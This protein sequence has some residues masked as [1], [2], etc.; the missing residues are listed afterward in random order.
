MSTPNGIESRRR[1]RSA[2]LTLVAL[3]VIAVLIG[4]VAVTCN[5]RPLPSFHIRRPRPQVP[6]KRPKCPKCSPS[7]RRSQSRTHR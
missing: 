3:A 7:G 4:L 2:G 1:R 5:R 6:L